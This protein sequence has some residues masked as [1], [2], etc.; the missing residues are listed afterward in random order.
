[1]PTTIKLPHSLLDTDLAIQPGN[2]S[3]LIDGHATDLA[4]LPSVDTDGHLLFVLEDHEYAVGAI[5]RVSDPLNRQPGFRFEIIKIE[6]AELPPEPINPSSKST[7]TLSRAVDT[8]RQLVAVSPTFVNRQSQY[9]AD[10]IE[11]IN[12]V[13]LYQA[14]TVELMMSMRELR[15]F[16]VVGLGDD[17]SW[18]AISPGCVN[19]NLIVGGGVF[20]IIVDN[21]RF[22]DLGS[23]DEED[24]LITGA[25]Q[26]GDSYCDFLNFSG[27][28]ADDMS[29]VFGTPADLIG[30]NG[31]ELVEPGIRT[32]IDQRQN[33]D[34]WAAALKF[35]FGE[36]S[37]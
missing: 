10:Q 9:G 12:R 3:I 5:V 17:I 34:Y 23:V 8:A 1:M 31:I 2:A 11:P 26:Q 15:P 13:Y 14:E 6:R 7:S 30:F 35:S 21:A 29:D 28:V 4:N 36:S 37:F 32:E 16:A 27:G 19:H 33:D 22:T 18:D 20:V 24:L 25:D